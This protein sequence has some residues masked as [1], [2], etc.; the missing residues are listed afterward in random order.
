LSGEA[1][2][3]DDARLLGVQLSIYRADNPETIISAIKTAREA[4]AQA[5]NILSSP[6]LNANRGLIIER[7][8]SA[9]LPA[10][11]Q[12]PEAVRDGGLVAYGPGF[13][14]ARSKLR[15]S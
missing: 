6:I 7:P 1:A 10:I 12:W 14:T 8:A 3:W 13:A 5:I 2:L 11:Y 9:R 15:V 4:G